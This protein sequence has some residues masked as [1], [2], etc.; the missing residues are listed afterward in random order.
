MNISELQSKTAV[1][2]QEL[3]KELGLN[4]ATKL[5]KNDLVLAIMKKQAEKEGLLFAHGI[6]EILPDGYGFLRVN[7]YEP[8]PDDVYVSPSQIRRFG[9]RTGDLVTGQVRR[10]KEGNGTTPSSGFWRP[11]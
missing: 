9:L 8:S 2:L 6:L 11:T 5:R 4:G 10:P 7:G 1:E 3:A